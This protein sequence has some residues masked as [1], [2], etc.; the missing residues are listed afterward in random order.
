MDKC[1]HNPIGLLG[2]VQDFISRF[3]IGREIRDL[4]QAYETKTN[5]KSGF[6]HNF[7]I[8]HCDHPACTIPDAK[9][10]Q[11]CQDNLGAGEGQTRFSQKPIF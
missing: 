5:P 9:D 6:C 3:K 1:L 7:Q 2:I 10:G 8:E 11:N 4:V